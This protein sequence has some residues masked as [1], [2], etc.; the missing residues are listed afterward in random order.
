MAVNQWSDLEAYISRSQMNSLH[1]EAFMETYHALSS[2]IHKGF[3]MN[4]DESEHEESYLSWVVNSAPDTGKSTALNVL[5]K[6]LLKKN[7]SNQH[8]KYPLL[9]VFN[10]NDTMKNNVYKDVSEFAKQHEIPDAIAMSILMRFIK[11]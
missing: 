3:Q 4:M 10:N 11:R 9:L 1:E 5:C 8:E 6:S 2:F 7:A